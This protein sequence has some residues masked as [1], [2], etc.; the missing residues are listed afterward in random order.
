ME[1]EAGGAGRML[2]DD[3]QIKLDINTDPQK[4]AFVV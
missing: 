2:F 1:Y 3:I 4:I